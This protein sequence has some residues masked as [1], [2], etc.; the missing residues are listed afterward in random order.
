MAM[1]VFA[2]VAPS[3][4]GCPSSGL[5]AQSFCV[6]VSSAC[7]DG[8]FICRG[9]LHGRF[10]CLTARFLTLQLLVFLKIV[11][12]MIDGLSRSALLV[13]DR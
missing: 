9:G 11:R 1:T 8:S 13:C 2:V 10:E 6:A 12:C 5:L 3:P 7:L 4:S